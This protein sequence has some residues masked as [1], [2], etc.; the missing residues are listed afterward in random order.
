M[1]GAGL[2][3]RSSAGDLRGVDGDLD[4]VPYEAALALWEGIEANWIELVTRWNRDGIRWR[5]FS[6]TEILWLAH[7]HTIDRLREDAPKRVRMYLTQVQDYTALR[8]WDKSQ[9]KDS[10]DK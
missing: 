10:S 7:T 9:M 6:F 5:D 1:D 3:P 8:E 4:R 2:R